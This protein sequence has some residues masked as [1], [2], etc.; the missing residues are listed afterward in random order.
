MIMDIRKPSL[1]TKDILDHY[2]QFNKYRG[3]EFSSIN[4]VFWCD[5]YN[6]KFTV[7]EDMLVFCKEKD[8]KAESFTFPVG[9]HNPRVAFD[10]ILAYFSEENMPFSMHMVEP[11]MFELIESWY[12]GEF[13]IEYDRDIADYLYDYE[14]LAELKGKKLHGKRNHI[15]RFLENNPDYQ[16]EKINGKNWKECLELE[17]AWEVANNETGDEDK[18]VEQ[19]IIAYSLEHR[20]SL[21]MVGAL[22]RVDGKVIAFTL[23]EPLTEDTFVVHFEKAVADIQGAYPMINREF[24]RQELQG[25][26]F[27]NREED[28]G[29]PGLRQAKL[30]YQPIKLVEKGHVTRR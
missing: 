22:L 13:Q 21:G 24:V 2:L 29:I 10:K 7:I 11:E 27:I 30:S 6:T 9:E 19:R 18:L 25:F 26:T 17:L 4:S 28:L 5:Y 3:C 12:P 23:G 1:K 15:N 16:Y 8:R 14:T 20:K